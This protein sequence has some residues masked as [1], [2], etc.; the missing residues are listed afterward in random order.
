MVVERDRP[1]SAVRSA[2][3]PVLSQGTVILR[4]QLVLSAVRVV[5]AVERVASVVGGVV[6]CECLYDVELD[7][8][9]VGEAVESKVGVAG[10]VVVC[11]V[12]HDTVWRL[13][14]DVCRE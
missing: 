2:N 11:C 9:V 13:G 5:V 10:W 12:V 6:F 4:P 7:E 3:G 14:Q 8:R 1:A